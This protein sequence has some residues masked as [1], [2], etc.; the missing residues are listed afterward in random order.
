MAFKIKGSIIV[1]VVIAAAISGWMY[2]GSIV[3]GGQST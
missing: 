2:T 3:I 1:A